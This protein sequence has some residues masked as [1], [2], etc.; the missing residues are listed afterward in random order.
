M[1]MMIILFRISFGR[2]IRIHLGFLD[3]YIMQTAKKVSTVLKRMNRD[4]L[5]SNSI[6]DYCFLSGK[7]KFPLYSYL[8]FPDSSVGKEFICNAGNPSSIPG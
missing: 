2:P 4:Y 1:K 7:I 6:P 8:N 5:I 3:I